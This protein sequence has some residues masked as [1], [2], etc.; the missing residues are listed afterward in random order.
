MI[1]SDVD[2]RHAIACGDI[3]LDPFSHSAIQPASIDLSLADEFAWWP[4]I[5][6][7]PLL[8]LSRPIRDEYRMTKSKADRFALRP[9]CFALAHTRERVQLGSR[10]MARVE[11]RSTLG[12]LGL[13]VHATA[14]YIDPGWD[15]QITLE[16]YNLSPFSMFLEAG[17]GICQLA[18]GLLSSAAERPYGSPGLGSKYQGQLGVQPSRWGD[19]GT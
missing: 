12:R 15:G 14:G 10:Y 16:L 8:D 18:V 6:G 7:T 19:K 4:A 9:G 5:Q 3:S 1:L 2:L 17:Q 13:M 11:G